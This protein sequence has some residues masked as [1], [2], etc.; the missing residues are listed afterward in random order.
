MLNSFFIKCF[1]AVTAAL[2]PGSIPSL[3]VNS[4]ILVASYQFIVNF[5]VGRSYRKYS[6]C[7]VTS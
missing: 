3:M 4:I 5:V 6:R 7:R 2:L 1:L